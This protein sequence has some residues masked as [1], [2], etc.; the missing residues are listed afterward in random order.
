MTQIDIVKAFLQDSIIQE[1]YSLTADEVSRMDLQTQPG[2]EA[3]VLVDLIKR[4]VQDV[5]DKSKTINAVASTMN[6]TLENAL[7]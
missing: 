7:R 6:L 1:Q 2:T 4:M 3:K 5:E